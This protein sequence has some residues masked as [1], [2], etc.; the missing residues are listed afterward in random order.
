MAEKHLDQARFEAV[1]LSRP[2]DDLVTVNPTLRLPTLID[3]DA[4]I[5]TAPIIASYLDERF[6]HPPLM[7]PEP[8]QRARVR[9]LLDLIL[10]SVFP[11]L[12]GDGALEDSLPA[13]HDLL[14]LVGP[15]H[16]LLGLDHHLADCAATVWLARLPETMTS[17]SGDSAQRLAGY[18]RRLLARPAVESLR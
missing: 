11:M 12:D 2:P 13:L 17:R 15:R 6:P 16:R 1:N 4:V 5:V 18:R 7:P 3:R 9:V 14:D 8:A 10:H